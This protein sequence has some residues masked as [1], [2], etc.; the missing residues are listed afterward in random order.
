VCRDM[1]AALGN[2]APKLPTRRAL[3][4]L[5]VQ[6]DSFGQGDLNVCQPTDFVERLKQVIPPYR[7]LGDII[8]VNTEFDPGPEIEA[9]ARSSPLPGMASIDSPARGTSIDSNDSAAHAARMGLENYFASSRQRA[10]KRQQARPFADIA[11]NEDVD[12]FEQDDTDEKIDDYL[13]K[14]RKGQLPSLYRPG[15]KGSD[16]KDDVAHLVERDKDVI[17]IKHHYSGFDAT[18]LLMTLRMKFVTHIYLAGLFS[19]VSIYETAADAV[20]HGFEVTVVEDCLGYRSEAKHID[21]MRKMADFLGVSG[22][23]SEEIVVEAG[24][25]APPDADESFIT[26]P[27]I[28][29]INPQ[30]FR[31][32]AQALSDKHP[33]EMEGVIGTD[34]IEVDMAQ[35]LDLDSSNSTSSPSAGNET[36]RVRKKAT[37]FKDFPTLGPGD[38]IGEGDSSVVYNAMSVSLAGEAFKLIRDEVDWQRMRLQGGEV[39]RRIA[40]QGDVLQ[41]GSLPLYRHP[42]EES[43]PL[44]PFSTT[45]RKVRDEL[46]RLL[47]QPFNH[48][49]IQ[50]YRDGSDNISE[51]SDKVRP[52]RLCY[53]PTTNTL[54]TDA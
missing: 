23:D 51:H 28:S 18:P 35:K 12:L 15:S 53:S 6:N 27:G 29:G 49:L 13:K 24:G 21:A 8:W 54:S 52:P 3:V 50:L 44:R 31:A 41:N 45:V 1:F 43:P 37:K 22:V 34:Q 17:L 33:T 9:S 20:R 14:P 25:Q 5:N 26:G 7:K 4:V 32:A 42:A 38:S 2:A 46:Q 30:P 10:K 16:F 47:K 19:N 40:V 11:L 36:P 39:P 48:V